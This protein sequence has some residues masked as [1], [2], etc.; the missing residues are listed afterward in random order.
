MVFVRGSHVNS[1]SALRPGACV[2][3]VM[4]PSHHSTPFRG[5][6]WI[7]LLLTLLMASY[8]RA[9]KL[10]VPSPHTSADMAFARYVA[11]QGQ[12]AAFAGSEPVVVLIE[13]SLPEL[14]KQAAVVA[15]RKQ[16][17]SKLQVLQVAGDGTVLSEVLDRYFSLREQLDEL[18]LDSI[19]ITPTN[20]KFH[21]GGEVNTGTAPAYVYDVS[22]KKK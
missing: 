20:Y 14:Y 2:G 5:H 16:G 12:G 13:A 17:E 22:P 7:A 9:A 15:L 11:T 8:G 4:Q 18:P 3:N 10:P 6:A 21:F 19:A 1:C